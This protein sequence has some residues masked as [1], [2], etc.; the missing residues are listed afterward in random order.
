MRKWGEKNWTRKVRREK[1]EAR[2]VGR[3]KWCYEMRSGAKR[4][5]GREK[6]GEKSGAKKK[7]CKKWDEKSGARKV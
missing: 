1:I 2:K 3:E 7:W 4:K 5:V 6:L